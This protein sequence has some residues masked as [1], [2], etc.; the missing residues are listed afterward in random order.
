MATASEIA[1]QIGVNKATLSKWRKREGCPLLEAGAEA[2]IEWH[3]TPHKNSGPKASINYNDEPTRSKQSLE[4]R[5]L[6][7]AVQ[8]NKL[9]GGDLK[10]PVLRQQ[11]EAVADQVLQIHLDMIDR[12]LNR[13]FV[14]CPGFSPDEAF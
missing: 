14:T 10:L 5:E 4:D 2:I 13:R 3:K 7:L 12:T 6:W 11:F 1:K 9:N 8:I